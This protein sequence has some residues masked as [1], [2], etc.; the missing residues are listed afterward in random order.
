MKN[1][2]FNVNKLIPTLVIIFIIFFYYNSRV[3]IINDMKV[4]SEN[5]I[6]NIEKLSLNT[7][8]VFFNNEIT[9]EF[10][11]KNIY[12]SFSNDSLNMYKEINKTLQDSKFN[13][14]FSITKINDFD[15]YILD[16]KRC[17]FFNANITVNIYNENGNLI[18]TE[19]KN[20]ESYIIEDSK[21]EPTLKIFE[22][23]LKN[24]Q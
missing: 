23:K 6:S 8:T 18:S 21:E 3:T 19:N 9:D 20:L 13:A 4:N 10:I 7:L 12:N 15:S 16:K 5:T 24:T 1:I 2:H 14:K 22:L 11:Q 17:Y